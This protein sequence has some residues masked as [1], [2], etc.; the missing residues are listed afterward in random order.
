MEWFIV[1]KFFKE[2]YTIGRLML[3]DHKVCDTLEDKVRELHDINHDGDFTDEGEG[4]V[5]G[6]T[7]IPCGKYRVTVSYSQKLKRRLPLINDVP[8]FTGIRI[9]KLRSAKG[10]EG[11]PGVGENTSKGKL[12]N[13]AYYETMI[14]RLID[15]AIENGEEVWITIKQ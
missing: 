12:S 13:G 8:G 15:E 9:H 3:G 7:A 6:E 14:V 10:T 4:K 1:R 11:C 5:Y 2:E